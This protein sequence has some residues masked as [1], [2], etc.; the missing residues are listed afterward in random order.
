MR[1]EQG[2]GRGAPRAV[3]AWQV[4]FLVAAA[5]LVG[6]ALGLACGREKA[7]SGGEAG[8]GAGAEDLVIARVGDVKITVHDL[9]SRARFQYADIKDLTGPSGI[10]QKWELLLA[11]FDQ[12]LWVVAG[13]RRGFDK[14]PEFREQLELS[15][16]FMLARYSQNKLVAE[17]ANPS[18]ETIQKYYE[19]NLDRFQQQAVSVAQIILVPTRTEAEALRRRA[20]GGED[21]A[22]LARR[23]SKDEASAASGG[24]IGGVGTTTIVPGF[25]ARVPAIN[26]ALAATSVGQVTPVIETP[27]GF[28]FFRV[29]ARKEAKTI[30][31]EEARPSILKWLTNS[32]SNERH[33]GIMDEVKR[34]S[35]ASIDTAAWR[36]YAFQTLSEDDVFALAD[37]ER[38]PE[39]RI[40]WFEA[41]ATRRPQSPRAAQALFLA[42]YAYAEDMKDYRRAGEIFKRMLEKYPQSELA[43]SAKWMLENMEKGLDNLPY[44]IEIKRRAYGG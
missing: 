19:D 2:S 25:A 40:G 44:A 22:G 36:E 32:K 11:A 38:R 6:G 30:S 5:L 9:E 16:Q 24:S 43:A 4:G 15:R 3:R 1:L 34:E 13:E 17:Q 10:K 7:R 29:S 39:R 33:Q 35:K 26:E 21:F 28:C 12:S 20:A 8:K 27:R 23:Y 41:Y 37:S 31:L 18:E 14:D 42:G